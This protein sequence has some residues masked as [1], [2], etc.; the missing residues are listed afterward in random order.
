MANKLPK[1]IS[2][3]LPYSRI[4][5]RK[6]GFR[7]TVSSY[8]ERSKGLI[9]DAYDVDYDRVVDIFLREWDNC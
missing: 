6:N 5:K 4:V 1:F 3:F 9:G 7:Q 8:M 2:E